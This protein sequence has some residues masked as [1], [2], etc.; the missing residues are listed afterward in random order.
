MI[1]PLPTPPPKTPRTCHTHTSKVNS[2][3][4][5]VSQGT[6]SE[7]STVFIVLPIEVLLFVLLTWQKLRSKPKFFVSTG[8]FPIL[9]RFSL[10]NYKCKRGQLHCLF[11][12]ERE[13]VTA[14]IMLSRE[15]V[16]PSLSSIW[17][18]TPVT[19]SWERTKWSKE[20]ERLWLRFSSLPRVVGQVHQRESCSHKE[21]A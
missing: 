9:P 12:K 4:I 11:I 19:K 14:F 7:Q 17:F 2:T 18:V 15:I 5:W 1:P 3:S 21:A 6:N 8:R 16:L 10:T 20:K 13:I